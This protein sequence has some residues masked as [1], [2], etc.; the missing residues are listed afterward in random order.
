MVDGW[1]LKNQGQ[2]PGTTKKTHFK[3]G[4]M[5][6][7]KNILLATFAAAL[8][9]ACSPAKGDFPGS[10]YMPDMAHSVAYEA[11][12]YNYYYLNTWDSASVYTLKDLSGP[13][14]PV[15]GTVPRGYAGLALASDAAGQKAEMEALNGENTVNAIKVPKNG[16]VPFYYQ[17]T[18][19]ERTRAMGEIIANPFPITAQGLEQ[20]KNLY[21][22]YCGICHGEKGDGA[23]YLVSEQNVNAKYPA[24]PANML[25]DEFVAASNGR[26]YFAI[27]YGKNVMGAYADKLN[28]EERWQVIHYIRSL[29]AKDKKLKYDE[30]ANTL[31]PVFGTPA[32]QLSRMAANAPAEEEAAPGAS[33]TEEGSH[34]SDQG[35]QTQGSSEH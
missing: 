20:G 23:G 25:L 13:R 29:Q 5:K 27:M 24:Q 14:L 26:Y 2:Q 34:N 7:I 33:A 10:E 8:L 4:E 21:T 35:G 30:G 18:E 6:K 28:Y 3:P 11:N 19:E 16:Y 22:I 17:N 1:W 15:K 31:N 9:Y 12:V 32:A